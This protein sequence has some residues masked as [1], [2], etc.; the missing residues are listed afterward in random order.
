MVCFR[1]GYSISGFTFLEDIPGTIGGAITT[2]AGT[3]NNNIADLVLEVEWFD[4]AHNVVRII[5]HN[6]QKGAILPNKD[7]VVLGA[8]LKAS[9]G[10]YKSIL[11]EM[12]E[13]KRRRYLNQPRQYPNAGSVFKHVLK[14]DQ[15]IPAWK[16]ID[17]VGLKGYSIGN[18]MVSDQHS[19][20]IIATGECLGSDV[21]KLVN[22]CIT[23]VN[24]KF[25]IK[26][27]LEWRLV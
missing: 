8:K 2:N 9:P 18:V 13:T 4:A 11:D 25:G 6:C 27:E 5:K 22:E 14:D 15:E 17:E 3:Y 1:K 7:G 21:V 19:G 16:L 26:L 10:D 20:F 12:L 24:N 23:R